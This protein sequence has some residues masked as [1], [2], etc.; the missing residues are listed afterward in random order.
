MLETLD[1]SG[2]GLAEFPARVLTAVPVLQEIILQHARGITDKQ[3]DAVASIGHLRR[4]DLRGIRGFDEERI[5]Q[6]VKALPTCEI[7]L[8]GHSK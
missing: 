5:R 7:L 4:L 8:P 3:V 6:L 2:A 1:L